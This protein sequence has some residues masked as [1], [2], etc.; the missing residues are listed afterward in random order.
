[1]QT[2]TSLSSW[3]LALRA[4]GCKHS[5]RFHQP[6]CRCNVTGIPL[7]AQQHVSGRGHLVQYKQ[8]NLHNRKQ[9]VIHA[10]TK[11]QKTAMKW[12][13]EPESQTYIL[14]LRNHG[15]EHVVKVAVN[16]AK[17]NEIWGLV[18]ALTSRRTCAVYRLDAGS[19]G[20]VCEES[21]PLPFWPAERRGDTTGDYETHHRPGWQSDVCAGGSGPER[22]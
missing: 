12:N 5:E 21:W 11:L 9:Y 3:N 22:L 2:Y 10:H 18:V 8:T 1:M 17:W 15:A 4:A 6:A 20:T 7:G 19:V 13:V 14:I 16:S